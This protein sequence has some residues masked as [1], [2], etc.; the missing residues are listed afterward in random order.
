MPFLRDVAHDSVSC[1]FRTTTTILYCKMSIFRPIN[2]L[3]STFS[4][5]G[6]PDRAK[7]SGP[8]GQAAWTAH[9]VQNHTL[10]GH[11]PP[12]SQTGRHGASSW[13][14]QLTFSLIFSQQHVLHGRHLSWDWIVHK[15]CRDHAATY[16]DQN[17]HIHSPI[18]LG[19]WKEQSNNHRKCWGLIF[20][21]KKGHLNTVRAADF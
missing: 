21:L 10:L 12:A 2:I 8:S 13:L 4:N 9:H 3:N 7:W 6:A 17:I 18:D 14:L 15:N 5:R 1:T 19:P 20:R 16:L 11:S